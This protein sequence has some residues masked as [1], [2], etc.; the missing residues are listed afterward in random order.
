M[1]LFVETHLLQLVTQH[2]DRRLQLLILNPAISDRL[3]DSAITFQPQVF[4]FSTQHLDHLP[5]VMD[6]FLQ[7]AGLVCLDYCVHSFIWPGMVVSA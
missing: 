3:L 5:E 7:A 6:F 4:Q 1:L 2:I